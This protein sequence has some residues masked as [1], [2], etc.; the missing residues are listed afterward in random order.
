MDT[1]QVFTKC[2]ALFC[3]VFASSLA[4]VASLPVASLIRHPRSQ[5]GRISERL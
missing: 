2:V 5:S 1:A 4:S 3:G